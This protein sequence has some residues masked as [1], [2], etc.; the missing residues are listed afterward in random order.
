[1]CG[2]TVCFLPGLG[3]RYSVVLV[4]ISN[5]ALL[6]MSTFCRATDIK[7]DVRDEQHHNP[8]QNPLTATEFKSHT[9]G[10]FTFSISLKSSSNL[11]PS[12]PPTFSLTFC[13]D[14]EKRTT[15]SQDFLF[16]RTLLSAALPERPKT[17]RFQ[18]HNGEEAAR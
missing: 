8:Q 12:A 4:M 11:V 15:H 5:T 13:N 17:G 3:C 16:W 18:R 6:V 7:H 2:L 10:L 9:V 1:M 14:G